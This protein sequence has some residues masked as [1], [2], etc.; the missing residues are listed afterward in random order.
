VFDCVGW[1]LLLKKT[2][3]N[4]LHNSSARYDAPKCDEDTRVEV[5]SEI[6]GCIED[7]DSPQ[8]RL[9]CMTGAAGSG[10]SA[11]Q[12]TVSIKCNKCNIPAASFFFSAT[13]PSRNTVEAV[14]PTIAYQLGRRNPLLKHQIK[15]AVE[16]EPLIFSQSLEA[17]M[18]GLIVE[19]LGHLKDMGFSICSPP[20]AILIDGLDE[21]NGE[22]RQ[23]ELLT[24]IRRCLLA[25]DLPFRIFIASRPE[26]AIRT[27]LEAGGHLYKVAYHIQLSDQYDASADMVRY[28]RR[29]F[30]G[31]GLH[32]GDPQWFTEDNIK[33]LV[34]A[35]SGQFI[36]VATVYKY[37]SERRASPMQRLMIVLTWTPHEAQIARPFQALDV[38]YTNILLAAKK[39]YEAV[40]THS[41]RDFLML[42]KA[43]HINTRHDTT[44]GVTRDYT[45]DFFSEHWLGLEARA[46]ESLISDLHSLVALERD[47]RGNSR[48]R[49]YHKS[50]SDFLDEESR[51]KD[52]FVSNARVYM[53]IAKYF[54]RCIIECQLD[55]DSGA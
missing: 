13:D 36:Y 42:V 41:G 7:R 18:V 48:L 47:S 12:Q 19:P 27:A 37:I 46:E 31:I 23:A 30:E 11:L 25:D 38:L 45:A 55:S 21:C 17:Q 28:L 40:D 53:H 50:F 10:K 51:A 49:L 22:D 14:I 16:D 3:P 54:M 29:R 5:T 20:Y 32:I 43:H 15:N 33:T 2:A 1:E 8:P 26:W 52:L 35:A 34:A 4:A 39:A 6:M 9:L 44:Y 24:A